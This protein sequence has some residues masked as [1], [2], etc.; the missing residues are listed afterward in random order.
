[1]KSKVEASGKWPLGTY[2]YDQED[3]RKKMAIMIFMHEYPLK[4]VKHVGFEDF[5]SS[6]EPLFKPISR[7]TI[8]SDIIKIFEHER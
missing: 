4:M 1:M 2:V 5:L 6:I 8:R 7:T 3:V